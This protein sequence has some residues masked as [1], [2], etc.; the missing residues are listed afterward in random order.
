MPGSPRRAPT[1]RE[2]HPLPPQMRPAE[3]PLRQ[4]PGL[5]GAPAIRDQDGP[6]SA[7]QRPR[8]PGPPAGV[9]QEHRHQ[10]RGRDPQPGPLPP[11]A[12]AGLVDVDHRL[13]AHVAHSLDHRRGHCRT[14]GLLAGRH[15]AHRQ[16]D[17]E[18]I[19]QEPGR[20]PLAQVIDPRAH[21]HRR[22]Q[23]GPKG[24]RRQPRRPR[25]GRRHPAARAR[26]GVPLV[27]GDRR[28]H[29]RHLGHL[30][31]PWGRIGPPQGRPAPAA[32]RRALR[33]HPVHL[34]HG[35]QRAGPGLVPRLGA[36]PAARGRPRR[37]ALAGRRIGRRGP[38]GVL[39]GLPQLLLQPRI[40][41]FQRVDP[42]DEAAND[43]ACLVQRE[44]PG[45]RHT[46]TCTL[47]RSH[48]P[49]HFVAEA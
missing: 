20:R 38:R 11:L 39:G 4:G 15:A 19:G 7:Q 43:L 45:R 12:P 36:R 21:G 9:D 47:P 1:L 31:A 42:L 32:V 6:R 10:G 33:D 8:R 40:L 34:L 13:L 28:P 14:G 23:P 46:P 37:R 41:G 49:Q 18:E 44:G 17:A 24:P 29:D 48:I 35:E 16:V 27:L 25:R 5:V 3:L 22:R 30:L 2:G 26:Q